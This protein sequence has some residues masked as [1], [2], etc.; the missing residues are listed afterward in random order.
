MGLLSHPDKKL[1]DHLKEVKEWGNFYKSINPQ[2]LKE[3]DADIIDSY[4]LFHDMGKGT[5]YFQ[6]YIRKEPVEEK[7]KSHA[8]ISA[9]LFLYYH[10][11]KGTVKE[12]EEIIVSMAYAI[13]KHHGDMESY[14]DIDNYL[15]NETN[16]GLLQQQYAAFDYQ[17][18]MDMGVR[19]GLEEE[20]LRKI[21]NGDAEEFLRTV[22][23]F[24]KDRRYKIFQ[25]KSQYRKMKTSNQGS[26]KEYYRLQLLYSI[27][28]DSDKSQVTIGTRK[29]AE[30]AELYADVNGYIDKKDTTETAL[31]V[32]RSQAF[33]EVESNIDLDKDIFTLTLPTGMGKTL[34][35]FN[36]AFKLREKLFQEK[37]IP[38]RIIYVLPFMS[39]IDQNARVI[40]DVLEKSGQKVTSRVLCKH[41]HLTEITWKTDENTLLNNANAEILLEGWN[42]EVIITTF[43]QFFSTLFG[44]KNSIQRK[45]NKM[46]HSIVIID[47]IQA[48]PVKYYNFAGKM[49]SEFTTALDSKVIAMTATQPR[50]FPQEIAKSLC[51]YKK[52]YRQLFRTVIYNE[53]D[54]PRTIEEFVEEIVVEEDRSYLFIL[55]TIESAKL[56]YTLLKNKYNEVP[57]TYLSTLIPPK[58]RLVRIDEIK[59][60]KYRIVVS[61]QLVEAGVDIDFQVVY[62]DLAPLPSLFQSAGR[63][64]REGGELKGEIHLIKLK[65]GN[66]YYANMVYREAKTDV[67]VTERILSNYK[68]LEEPDFMAVIEAYFE[69]ISDDTV[70]SQDISKYLLEGASNK[71]FYGEKESAQLNQGI[72]PLN[73]FELIEP[74]SE[75]YPVFI[76]LDGDAA[77]LWQEYIQILKEKEEPW[78]HKRKLKAIQREMAEYVVDVRAFTRAKYNKP[79]KGENELYYYVSYSELDKYYDE[80][81]GYGV[82]SSVYYY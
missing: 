79:Q 40:E 61:T 22:S 41:H 35:S 30:R 71:R 54:K 49:L 75:K 68:V 48:L 36:F 14:S 57:I 27:L 13:L 51:D 56:M 47:E 69:K 15:S 39:I 16:N 65:G 77:D 8:A 23:R 73:Y 81:T 12:R 50:I 62:R 9:M 45:F 31:N 10:I 82:E 20:V 1:E 64:N 76:E 24:L 4:L 59:K 26:F 3:I 74:E 33:K 32:L 6:K 60:K 43:Q 11:Q 70:K 46:C 78:E 7:L 28:L 17:A 37:G 44:H 66:G 42:S 80:T 2:V 19:V 67:D 72:L 18:M 34:N 25:Q 55:N 38:Y 29:L 5:L 52:Y 58:E 53:L 63:G 21:F